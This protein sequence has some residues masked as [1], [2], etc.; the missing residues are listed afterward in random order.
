MKRFLKFLKE[1]IKMIFGLDEKEI[2]EIEMPD[3]PPPP[4]PELKIIPKLSG[5]YVAEKTE[6]T[7]IVLHYTGGGTLSGAEA[8]L[9]KLD[10]VNVHYGIDDDGTVYQYIDEIY[11]AYHTGKGKKLDRRAIG[12]EIRSWG[13]LSERNGKYYSWTG[14][15]IPSEKVIKLQKFR[16]FQYWEK[17]A[18]EQEWAIPKLI[19]KI[20][21]RWGNNIIIISHAQVNSGKLDFPPDY[22]GIKNL[23]TIP[24]YDLKL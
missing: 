23:I 13:H 12:I 16:G 6:K 18:S 14:K 9:G 2:I 17:L 3:P 5:D 24:N 4:E 20:K 10:K 19:Q 1:L 7:I 11:W 8:E 15:E 21:Q 22:P